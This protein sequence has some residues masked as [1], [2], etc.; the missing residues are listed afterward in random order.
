MTL[1]KWR[2][3]RG[4]TWVEGWGIWERAQHWEC[5]VGE[6][7]PLQMSCRGGYVTLR[8][9]GHSEFRK[10]SVSV[11]RSWYCAGVEDVSVEENIGEGFLEPHYTVPETYCAFFFLSKQNAKRYDWLM[12]GGGGRQQEALAAGRRERSQWEAQLWFIPGVLCVHWQSWLHLWLLL[13]LGS[14][15]SHRLLQE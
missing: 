5:S 3:Y 4:G 11:S 12:R 8:I 14:C 1:I 10:A 13:S 15:L 2:D 9:V 7:I 6:G